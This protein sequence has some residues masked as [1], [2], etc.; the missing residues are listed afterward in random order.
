MCISCLIFGQA[1]LLCFDPTHDDHVAVDVAIVDNNNIKMIV[2]SNTPFPH[3]DTSAKE[4]TDAKINALA[5]G[6]LEQAVAAGQIHLTQKRIEQ[7][8][9]AFFEARFQYAFKGVIFRA[10]SEQADSRTIHGHNHCTML[11]CYAKHVALQLQKSDKATY[12]KMHQEVV[13]KDPP[14]DQ[15]FDGKSRY[16][17][18]V[19][20]AI[21]TSLISN[22]FGQKISITD[23]NW[24]VHRRKAG[25][26]YK[27]RV[28]QMFAKAFNLDGNKGATIE[29]IEDEKDNHKKK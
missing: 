4:A 2:Y 9:K 12:D 21:G 14:T 27:L 6:N 25:A 5:V 22:R 24:E 1:R 3:D 26:Q 7:A 16:E 17:H 23:F 10:F 8:Y 20:I 15:T 19:Q 28:K 13:T 29:C 18:S 11:G